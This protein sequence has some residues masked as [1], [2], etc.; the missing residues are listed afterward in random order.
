MP[1]YLQ[2]WMKAWMYLL[3]KIISILKFQIVIN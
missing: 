1:V 2:D 3:P